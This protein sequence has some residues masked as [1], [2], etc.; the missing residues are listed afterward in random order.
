MMTEP[1]KSKDIDEFCPICIRP[2]SKHS[3]E[4]M[5][6]CSKKLEEFKKIKQVMQELNDFKKTFRLEQIFLLKIHFKEQMYRRI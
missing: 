1:P 3:P 2:K 6:I 5:L 4:E